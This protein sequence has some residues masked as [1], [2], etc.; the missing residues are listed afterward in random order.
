M[1][2][3]R[4]Q[5]GSHY[6]Y[7]SEKPVSRFIDTLQA[8]LLPRLKELEIKTIVLLM[9][10]DEQKRYYNDETLLSFYMRNGLGMI[11]YPIYDYENPRPDDMSGF[12]Q[13][14][15]EAW[16]ALE[17]EN[18][19][20]H[21]SAGLGRTGLFVACM[22]LYGNVVKTSKEAIALVRKH[23]PF[24]VEAQSQE[25]FIKDFEDELFNLKETLDN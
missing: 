22:L 18:I 17:K 3:H 11:Y 6:L 2:A 21:C 23:R 4:M 24:A 10:Q 7:M 16:A 20:V 5:V 14:V 15:A 25:W 1:K 19:L 13:K 8:T 9:P 12:F